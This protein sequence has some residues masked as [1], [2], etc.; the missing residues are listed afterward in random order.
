MEDVDK[1][2]RDYLITLNIAWVS[3]DVE[4]QRGQNRKTS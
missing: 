2:S 3:R 4:E 1:L